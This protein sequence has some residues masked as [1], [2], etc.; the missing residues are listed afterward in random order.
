MKALTTAPKEADTGILGQ[1]QE[2]ILRMD[3][4]VQGCVVGT[5][6]TVSTIFSVW[7]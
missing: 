1:N 3:A 6:S 7:E 2:G 5:L 4:A